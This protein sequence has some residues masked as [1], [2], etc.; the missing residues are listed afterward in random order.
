MTYNVTVTV[1]F[2]VS[3]AKAFDSL[4]ELR[5]Y[6]LWNSGMVSILYD[7]AMREGMQYVS[8]SI[9]VGKENTATVRID[10]FIKNESIKLSSTS[11]AIP[12]SA[13]YRL[14]AV[15]DHETEVLCELQF[16][17][18]GIVLNFAPAVIES[19]AKSRIRGD[20]ETLRALIN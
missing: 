16:A 4:S 9:V 3:I 10:R 8:K 17:L 19:M 15:S 18:K 5:R 12:F 7:G 11:G 13:E 14:L 20:L 2:P 6:P 1:L